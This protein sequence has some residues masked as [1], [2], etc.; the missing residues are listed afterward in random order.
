MRVRS[1]NVHPRLSRVQTK[2]RGKKTSSNEHTTHRRMAHR[3]FAATKWTSTASAV[4]QNNQ[5]MYLDDCFCAM[6]LYFVWKTHLDYLS[7]TCTAATHC[8]N[9]DIL[10]DYKQTCISRRKWKQ[11]KM[12]HFLCETQWN[13]RWGRQQRRKMST[14]ENKSSSYNTNINYSFRILFV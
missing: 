11:R 12:S 6:S 2:W 10:R 13:F 9:I 5:A 7:E 14:K 3:N 8:Y 4:T 1:H